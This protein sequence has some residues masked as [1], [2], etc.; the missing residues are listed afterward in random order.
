[1]QVIFDDL[2]RYGYSA[3]V[4]LQM[5]QCMLT[6]IE[7]RFCEIHE[8]PSKELTREQHA[9]LHVLRRLCQQLGDVGYSIVRKES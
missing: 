8:T 5:Q 3:G 4:K 7:R 9:E 6:M 1:M 2:S